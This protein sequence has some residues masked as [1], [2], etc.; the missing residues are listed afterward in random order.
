MGQSDITWAHSSISLSLKVGQ[1]DVRYS[2]HGAI[3]ST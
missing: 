2:W 1:P 3:G